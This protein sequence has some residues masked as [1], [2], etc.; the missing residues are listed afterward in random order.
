[1]VKYVFTDKTN[2]DKGKEK[3]EPIVNKFN[4]LGTL[5][6]NVGKSNVQI[7]QEL[8]ELIGDKNNDTIIADTTISR[9][10]NEEQFPS[11]NLKKIARYFNVP[12]ADLSFKNTNDVLELEH[13]IAKNAIQIFADKLDEYLNFSAAIAALSNESNRKRRVIADYVVSLV[14]FATFIDP[15]VLQYCI[16]QQKA[17]GKSTEKILKSNHKLIIS[18]IKFL[19]NFLFKFDTLNEIKLIKK[20]YKLTYEVEPRY[21]MYNI[22]DINT[23]SDMEYVALGNMLLLV[24]SLNYFTK[25]ET[26]KN[27]AWM[28]R[29]Q[30][31]DYFN[32]LLYS[33]NQNKRILELGNELTRTKDLFLASSYICSYKT[34]FMELKKIVAFYTTAKFTPDSKHSGIEQIGIY[35]SRIDKYVH[36]EEKLPINKTFYYL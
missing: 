16:Q 14:E 32:L 35:D 19:D 6:R 21:E 5:I 33:N 17:E 1:M 15:V 27:K 25:E 18:L 29:K 28:I 2:T 12:I 4:N 8:S 3:K 7:A 23:S 20:G 24:L 34:S 13:L 22:L 36:Q 30:Q 26:K 9:W 11:R 31:Q 10:K